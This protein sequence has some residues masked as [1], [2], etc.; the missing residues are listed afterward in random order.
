MTAGADLRLLRAAVF[1]AACVTVSAA[2]HVLAAGT[3][4]PLVPLALGFGCVFALAVALAGRERSLPGIAGLLTL[5]Q[6]ALHLLFSFG[7]MGAQGSTRAAAGTRP[8]PPG[9][10]GGV[11]ELAGKLLCNHSAAG[12]SEA[13]ARR[14]VSRAGL[15]PDTAASAAGSGPAG[16]SAH[17][18]AHAASSAPFPDTPLDCLRGAARAAVGMF[19]APMLLGHLCAALLLG[20][21]LRRGEAA[22]WRLVRLSADAADAADELVAA[23]A[24][25]RALAYVRAWHAGL[26]PKAPVRSGFSRPRDER[27]PRS[28]TLDH[29]V[30]R[31]GPPARTA[32][33]FALAA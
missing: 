33:A 6:F 2:G 5:G 26:P 7:T 11:R 25:S 15:D 3:M 14:V 12:M 9:G 28:V 27:A 24:L 1:A 32:D 31:R 21:L 10:P 4:V 19:D 30:H 18:A 23:L 22:L 17:H 8:G 29:T 16:H 20:W 13:D